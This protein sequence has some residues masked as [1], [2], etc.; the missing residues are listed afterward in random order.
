MGYNMYQ[1]LLA[2]IVHTMLPKVNPTQT[3]AWPALKKHYNELKDTKLQTMFE[4]DPERFSRFS[5]KTGNILWDFSKNL[6]QEQTLDLFNQLFS[7]CGLKDAISAQF[8]G[9]IINETEK[10]AVLHTALRNFSDRPVLV[11][12][13]D[14]M[15][16]IQIEL[17][18]MRDFSQQIEDGSWLGYTGK[19]IRDIVNIGIGGSDL[20]PAMMYEA[21]RPY[22][23]ENLRCHFVSNVDEAH[24]SET[25]KNLDREITLFII[26]SKTFTTQ[27][28]MTNAHTARRWFIEGAEEAAVSKH[29]VA[30]STNEEKVQEFGIDTRNM[31]VFWDWVGGRYSVWSAIGLSLCC[32]IGYEN[33]EQLLR[34]AHYMDE[35]F[36]SSTFHENVP[37][38]MAAIGIWYVNFWGAETEAIIPYQ[39]NLSRFAAYFQQ[40]N[41]E[42]NGK[43]V[44]RNGQPVKY[45]TGPIVWGEPGTNGQHAFFQLIHQGTRLIPC[46][47]IGFAQSHYP[48]QDHQDKL[49]ANF[50]AQTEALMQGRSREQAA[51]GAEPGSLAELQV[52]YRVF[53]GGKPTT[54]I[55]G[56]KLDPYNLGLLVA[57]YE[58]KIFVQGVVWNIYSYDQW[59]VELGKVLA[60]KI[61]PELEGNA[62]IGTHDASTAGLI[63]F[64]LANKD[65]KS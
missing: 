12:G 26:A 60:S 1:L 53:E 39:Q 51:T 5:T 24:I 35:H 57:A 33:Y 38:I 3:S 47:F 8:K 40:G 6:I 10:R 11:D 61:L 23:V 29:F 41:M 43:S 64:Y 63:S 42:S 49:M 27:E 20:G 7:E 31:F 30:V 2:K 50:F 4:V 55:L 59:G 52:P 45:Q 46:D 22:H 14:V 44:D 62:D 9:D 58:H 56:K 16:D 37:M 13:R 25:L 54:T 65:R 21:L 34:G 17:A 32:G 28:T 36:R 18:K 48:D 15:P 19:P